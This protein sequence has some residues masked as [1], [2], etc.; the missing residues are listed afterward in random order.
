[1]NFSYHKYVCT[2]ENCSKG[3]TFDQQTDNQKDV[4][5]EPYNEK[6]IGALRY[7]AENNKRKA[8]TWKAS[9]EEGDQDEHGS[10]SNDT[11]LAHLQTMDE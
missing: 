5:S 9:Q 7:S 11:G 3:N 1:M 2:T 4:L 10:M 6:Q 8:G